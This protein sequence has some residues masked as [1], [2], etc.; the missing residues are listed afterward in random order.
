M[1]NSIFVLSNF[2]LFLGFCWFMGKRYARTVAQEIAEERARHLRLMAYRADLRQ[3]VCAAE[4]AI[5]K[6]ALIYEDLSRKIALWRERYD[7]QV[8]RNNQ[9]QQQLVEN[10]QKKYVQQME[11]HAVRQLYEQLLPSV[12][13]QAK[14]DL[15][16]KF[17]TTTSARRYN[18]DCLSALKHK[19]RNV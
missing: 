18:D 2:V 8:Q 12:I 19:Q 3:Q 15:Q 7:I 6:Q 16:Q 9:A 5:E 13:E 1:I 4:M 14:K 10:V 11:A 17:D